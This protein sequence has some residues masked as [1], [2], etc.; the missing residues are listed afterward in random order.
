MIRADVTVHSL[1]PTLL[2]TPLRPLFVI[3]TGLVLVA[4]VTSWRTVHASDVMGIVGGGALA[5]GVAL[6]LDDEANS[7]LRSSPTGA[8]TRLGHR[9]AILLPAALVAAMT[10]VVADHLLFIQ[11]PAN[12]SASALAALIATGVAVDVWWSRR[13][14]E[15]AAEG[16]AVVVMAWALAGSFVPDVWI[17]H[18]FAE[19]WHLDAPLVL[20]FSIVLVI[21][22]TAGRSA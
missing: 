10:L 17:L 22:G 4:V 19:A 2:A 11:G 7:M 14:P 15:T 20:V 6:G 3:T 8:L 18:R 12:V 9:L 5:G 13:R 16:A 1:R 21:A